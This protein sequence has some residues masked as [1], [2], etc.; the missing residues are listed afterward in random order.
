MKFHTNFCFLKAKKVIQPEKIV[1]SGE[2]PEISLKVQ[3]FGV[4]KKFV[5]LMQ[6]FPNSGKGCG[7]GKFPP[8][9]WAESEILPGGIFLPGKGN[10]RMSDFD[11]LNLF[12][13]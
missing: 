6:G 1:I 11:D 13:S 3:L 2:K 9:R 7:G 12:Q 5:Q 4:G 10:L 8:V